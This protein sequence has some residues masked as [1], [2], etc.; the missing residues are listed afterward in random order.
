MV[1]TTPAQ[2]SCRK[3]VQASYG[4][5][6]EL[7]KCSTE[8]MVESSELMWKEASIRDQVVLLQRLLVYLTLNI[9]LKNF[10]IILVLGAFNNFQ[11]V[12]CL[13]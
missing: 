10:G 13:L 7:G 12:Q 6:S 4:P 3:N 2:L 9:S 1:G 11:H 8:E 5:L